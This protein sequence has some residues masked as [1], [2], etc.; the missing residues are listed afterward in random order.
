[1]HYGAVVCVGCK[2]FFRRALMKA[3]QLECSRT[4]C[5]S[6]RFQRCREV[7][8]KPEAC[9]PNRDYT[10]KQKQKSLKVPDKLIDC[11]T[12]KPKRKTV[13]MR[14]MSVEMKTLLMN[15]LNIEAKVMKGDTSMDALELYPLTTNKL[16]DFINDP[17]KLKG[18]RCEMRYEPF[19]MAENN[20]LSTVS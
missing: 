7:G 6:C 5:R 20:D 9:R 15:L 11:S 16:R 4:H 1:M 2:G 3:D 18:K 8:M 12:P 14:K 10:G 19:R 13:W 17:R